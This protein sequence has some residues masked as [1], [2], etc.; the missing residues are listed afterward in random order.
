[1]ADFGLTV[2]GTSTQ[3]RK[4]EFSRGTS[5]Y[6]A[7]ELVNPDGE[8]TFTNKVDIWAIG[9][10][11]YEVICRKRAFQDDYNV[12]LYSVEYRYF[13][14]ELKIPIDPADPLVDLNT[15]ECLRNIIHSMLQIDPLK[16][17]TAKDLCQAFEQLLNPNNPPQTQAQV[18]MERSTK[19]NED[20]DQ[21]LNVNNS[22]ISSY[23]TNT[24]LCNLTNPRTMIEQLS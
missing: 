19:L 18:S 23:L 17:P 16:R 3:P 1:M 5:S 21:V 8:R 7:P 15:K 12:S 14:S 4:T 20:H 13:K 24:K 9:C 22:T 6:R 10:I 2:E 11:L